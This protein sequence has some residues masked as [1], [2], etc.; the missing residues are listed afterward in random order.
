MVMIPTIITISLPPMSAHHKIINHLINTQV[1]PITQ[2]L[3]TQ[4]LQAGDIPTL[5]VTSTILTAIATN[6]RLPPVSP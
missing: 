3:L 4:A 2:T 5:S 6:K 1:V